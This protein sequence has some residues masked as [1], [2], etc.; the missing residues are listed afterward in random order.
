MCTAAALCCSVDAVEGCTA[1]TVYGRRRHLQP[2]S[3]CRSVLKVVVLHCGRALWHAL[4]SCRDISFV[5]D[6]SNKVCLNL[7]SKEKLLSSNSVKVEEIADLH[8]DVMRETFRRSVCVAFVNSC[9]T[10][11]TEGLRYRGVTGSSLSAFSAPVPSTPSRP[12]C[13]P[14]PLQAL[15]ALSPAHLSSQP[16]QH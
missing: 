7:L 12:L 10:T 9:D 1:G 6:P 5:G 2:A 3:R 15:R 16:M 4:C 11:S 8:V 14:L 13:P